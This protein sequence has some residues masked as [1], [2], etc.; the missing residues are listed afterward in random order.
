MGHVSDWLHDHNLQR[1]D[2]IGSGGTLK[3][4][5]EMV[6]LVVLVTMAVMTVIALVSPD[7]AAVILGYFM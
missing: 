3:T 2:Q 6:L 5:W 4:I 7:T 1:E